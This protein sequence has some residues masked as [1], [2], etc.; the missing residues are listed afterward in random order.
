MAKKE[1]VYKDETG[2]QY[3]IS[4]S[5]ELQEKTLN[6]IRRQIEWEKKNFYAKIF[7]LMIIA[8]LTV[9]ILYVFYRLD[10]INFFTGILYR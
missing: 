7:L 1:M 10:S 5:E 2:H 8:I 3:K 4:Y 9:S 6:A